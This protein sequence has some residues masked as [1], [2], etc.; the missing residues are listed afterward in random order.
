[1]NRKEMKVVISIEARMSSSRLPGKMLMKI[2]K[3]SVIQHLVDRLR[4]C[5]KVDD[6]IIATTSNPKD[7][8]LVNWAK[9]YNVKYYRGSEDDVLQR[10]I[11]ANESI[12]S[13]IIVEI[14]G[15]CPFT[16]PE[17]VDLAVETYKVNDCDYLT[18]C[19][20]FSAP[21]GLYVQVFSLNSL[22]KIGN[23]IKDPAVREHVSLY[24]YE[25]PDKYKIIH[26]MSPLKWELPK[27]TRIYLDYEEDLTFLRTIDDYFAKKNIEFYFADDIVK[28]L[29]KNPKLLEI[30]RYKS[31]VSVR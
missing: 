26:L 6:I 2:G 14:T 30:N 11:D 9:E 29:K 13:D 27:D 24:Y 22:K 28:L 15:D 1:M 12:N 21:P 5:N 23:I 19:E 7:D 16:D 31:D 3:K 4:M 25:N 17:I 10:V 8:I 18:N 20:I